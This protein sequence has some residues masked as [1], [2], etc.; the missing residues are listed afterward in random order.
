MS[1]YAK[2]IFVPKRG[3]YV[4]LERLSPRGEGEHRYDEKELQELLFRNPAALPT[5]EIDGAFSD[6]VPVCRELRTS[7]GPLDLLYVTPQGGI[8][9]VEVKLWCWLPAMVSTTVWRTWP[10]SLTTPAVNIRSD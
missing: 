2:P 10:T 8:V 6:L 9:L 3:E 4:Q 5:G 7:S 1:Q